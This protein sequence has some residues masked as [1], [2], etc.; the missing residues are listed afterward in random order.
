MTKTHTAISSII[1]LMLCAQTA[2]AANPPPNVQ[3]VT[4]SYVGQTLTVNWQP[5]ADPAGIDFYRIYYSRTS[6]L[7]NQGNFDDLVKTNGPVTTYSFDKP[8]YG[9]KPLYV[10]VMAVNKAGV[11]SEAFASEASAQMTDG[12]GAQSS[13]QMSIASS[14]ANAP[15]LIVGTMV[16]SADSSVPSSTAMGGPPLT[17]QSVVAVSM[18]GVSI[19]FSAPVGANALVPATYLFVDGSGTL[20]AISKVEQ[21]DP[22]TV[23]LTTGAQ[24]PGRVYSYTF[25]DA[26]AGQDGTVMQKPL[27]EGTF[28]GFGAVTPTPAPIV[29]DRTPPEDATNLALAPSMQANRLYDVHAVWTASLNTAGDLA[30]YFVYTTRD[31]VHFSVG[32]PLETSA[33]DTVVRGVAPGTFGVKVT[34]K[35]ASGNESSGIVSMTN[36]PSSGLPLIGIVV[37]AGAAAGR[38]TMRRSRHHG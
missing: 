13:A 24:T 26:V 12:G 27:P 3:G 17:V 16:S 32:A 1:T 14:T 18:T 36:L 25:M 31:G 4:A 7:N 22:T 34:T 29:V 37:L 33:T 20:L 5:V 35:D 21:Q 15:G 30:N 6:I 38:R 28:T 23:L 2:F 8:P 11:E 19:A 10:S 9:G